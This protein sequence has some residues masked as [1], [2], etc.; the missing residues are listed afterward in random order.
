[1]LV[2]LSHSC[3]LSPLRSKENYSKIYLGSQFLIEP[4]SLLI[5]TISQ[6]IDDY[7]VGFVQMV[8]KRSPAE[9][10]FLTI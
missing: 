2:V 3:G 5:K 6:I 10:D 7:V 8:K 1:M 9:S 4:K